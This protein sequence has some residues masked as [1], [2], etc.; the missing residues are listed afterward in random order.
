RPEMQTRT[1]LALV[2]GAVAIAVTLLVSPKVGARLYLAPVALATSA[3]AGWMVSQLS[4]TR[5]RAAAWVFALGSIPYASIAGGRAYRGV[6][7]GAAAGL[8]LLE[9]APP[10][11]V[12]EL[13]R[14]TIH[15]SRWAYDDDLEI[16]QL[17]N[18]VSYSFGLALIKLTGKPAG[19]GSDEP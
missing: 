13:P 12:L 8:A 6:G 10:N 18:T 15:R 9:H 4:G 11:S 17:R 19:T 5:T 7:R 16:E 1:E 14:Y 2:A 3:A